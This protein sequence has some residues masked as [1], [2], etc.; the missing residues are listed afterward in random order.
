MKWQFGA[1]DSNPC[2]WARAW[3]PH[4]SVFSS[5][6]RSGKSDFRISS[7]F[8]GCD[9]RPA[10]WFHR[11]WFP[12]LVLISQAVISDSL[13][14]WNF[15][16]F[17]I[18]FWSI[19][20]WFLVHFWLFLGWFLIHFVS[21]F[22]IISRFNE[23]GWA[24]RYV[25]KDGDSFYLIWGG[26][27]VRRQGDLPVHRQQYLVYMIFD[28][29]LVKHHPKVMHNQEWLR[30]HVVLRNKTSASSIGY[31]TCHHLKKRVLHRLQ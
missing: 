16:R 9:F 20:D 28:D 24:S 7:D 19:F 2:P 14:S 29:Q 1:P 30:K 6:F 8:T 10:F 31:W 21:I 25:Q 5:C 3:T 23:T 17:L 27:A 18:D 4:F 15:G 12:V 22:R 11:L 26:L 13:F